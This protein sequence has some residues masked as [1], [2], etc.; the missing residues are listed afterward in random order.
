MSTTEAA[1]LLGVSNSYVRQLTRNPPDAASA[2]LEC[3]AL[4]STGGR[5]YRYVRRSAV[6]EL[7]NSGSVR[8]RRPKGTD[9][10]DARSHLDDEAPSTFYEPLT[11]PVAIAQMSAQTPVEGQGW[12][13]E[14]ELATANTRVVELTERVGA[15]ELL[16]RQLT[17]E[18]SEIRRR[19]AEL[20]RAQMTL[21]EGYVEGGSQS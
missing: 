20:A 15:L 2:S 1:L 6:L 3:I 11:Q 18:N 19:L 4:T 9:V 5:E 7:R 12:Q 14:L 17:K 10:P 13:L 16:N 21:L 8:T